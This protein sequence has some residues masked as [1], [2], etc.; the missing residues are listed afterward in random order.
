MGIHAP[1]VRPEA[2]E[3]PAMHRAVPPRLDVAIPFL[4]AHRLLSLL[5]NARSFRLHSAQLSGLSSLLSHRLP[6]Y[7]QRLQSDRVSQAR[8]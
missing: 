4:S 8:K 1:L 2:D 7:I 6:V 5:L 3:P